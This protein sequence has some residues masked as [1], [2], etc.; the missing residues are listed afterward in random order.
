[1]MN[2][3][4]KVK[5]LLIEKKTVTLHDCGDGSFVSNL[6]F[7]DEFVRGMPVIAEAQ[8]RKVRFVGTWEIVPGSQRLRG[9]GM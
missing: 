7:G 5:A 8:A 6:E 1:M 2:L 3:R 9:S 4:E